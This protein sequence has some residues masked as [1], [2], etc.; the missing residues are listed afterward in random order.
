MEL[1]IAGGVGEHGRNCFFLQNGGDAILVDCGLMAGSDDPL[2]RLTESQIRKLKAVFLT[3]SH[4]DH[5]GALPWLLR[6]GYT[7][8]IIS[9]TPTLQQL[10]FIVQNAV[11]LEQVAP[12]NEKCNG[13]T[14]GLSGHCEGSVWLKLDWDD[15]AILFSGDYTEQS[16]VYPCDVLR[17]QVADLAVLDCAY[18]HDS[19]LWNDSVTAAAAAVENLLEKNSNRLFACAEIWTWS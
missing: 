15:K 8:P 10:P 16:A 9:T 19:T 5:T 13:I 18:G 1:Y 2:P 14:W 12:R 4:A 3:H 6:Q 11:A 17:N 7:G